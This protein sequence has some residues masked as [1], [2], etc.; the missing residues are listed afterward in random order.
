MVLTSSADTNNGISDAFLSVED[1][2]EGIDPDQ[3]DR[4]QQ[5]EPG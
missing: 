3:R 5:V 2:G 1:T 4:D